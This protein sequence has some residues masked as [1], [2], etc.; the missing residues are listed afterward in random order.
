MS[1]VEISEAIAELYRLE[2]LVTKRRIMEHVLQI[3]TEY[4]P[5]VWE[6]MEVQ[7]EIV[8]SLQNP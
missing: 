4:L 8:S 1:N 2:E 6:A 5:A 7:R 3:D